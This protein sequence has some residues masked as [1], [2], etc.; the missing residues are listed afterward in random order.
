MKKILI[1]GL[2]VSS[3]VGAGLMTTLIAPVAAQN[4]GKI[5]RILFDRTD[6]NDDGFISKEEFSAAQ[7]KRFNKIDANDD[8]KLSFEENQ[9]A[10]EKTRKRLERFRK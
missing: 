8:G 6:T 4:G 7:L 9:K 5:Q 1:S 2:V 10:I 3:L